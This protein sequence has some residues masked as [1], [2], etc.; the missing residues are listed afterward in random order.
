MTFWNNP[1]A[2]LPKQQFR[3]IVSFDKHD[4]KSNKEVQTNAIPYWFVKSVDKP[5]FEIKSIQLKHLYSDVFNFPTRVVWKPIKITLLDVMIKYDPSN[6]GGTQTLLYEK[7]YLNPDNHTILDKS[8]KP[9][10]KNISTQLFFYKFL[11]EA[12]YYNPE[13]LDIEEKL[14]RYRSYNFKKNMINAF[15][16]DNKLNADYDYDNNKKVVDTTQ[17]NTFKIIELDEKGNKR[18]TWNLYNPLIT[19]VNFDKL[20]YSSENIVTINATIAYDWAELVIENEQSQGAVTTQATTA[21]QAGTGAVFKAPAQ[22]ARKAGLPRPKRPSPVENKKRPRP[23]RP[24]TSEE[25]KA[26]T[27]TTAGRSTGGV[28]S[29]DNK[30]TKNPQ[31]TAPSGVGGS[32][33]TP[34]EVPRTPSASQISQQDDIPKEILIPPPLDTLSNQPPAQIPAVATPAGVG[35]QD[36]QPISVPST[37]IPAGVGSEQNPQPTELDLGPLPPNDLQAMD[38]PNT[39]RPSGVGNEQNPAKQE[40]PEPP[41]PFGLEEQPIQKPKAEKMIPIA[42]FNIEEVPSIKRSIERTL[43]V[44]PPGGFTENQLR[45]SLQLS[46]QEFADRGSVYVG[47]TVIRMPR[48][49]SGDVEIDEQNVKIGNPPPTYSGAPERP[50]RKSPNG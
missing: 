44:N 41:Q 20:D 32:N 46:D 5:S 4:Y 33:S 3:W 17:W 15:V 30:S 10:E 37:S 29:R 45:K 39:S 13:E 31:A 47:S 24:P 9:P 27:P 42:K 7:P 49:K 1:S 26:E 34:I 35:G 40:L 6:S 50:P 18:E 38:M 23:N 16:G 43:A 21:N 8:A 14:L 28:G 25:K 19:D 22:E 36:S 48:Q 12:G 2:L 11:Q